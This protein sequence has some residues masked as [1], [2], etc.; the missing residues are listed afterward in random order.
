[1]VKYNKIL[2]PFLGHS[3]NCRMFSFPGKGKCFVFDLHSRVDEKVTILKKRTFLYNV[4]PVDL[5]RLGGFYCP[6]INTG[7]VITG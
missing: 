3:F 4:F 7:R 1:M 5:L 2:G 6:H